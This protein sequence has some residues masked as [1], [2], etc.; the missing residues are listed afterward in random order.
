MTWTFQPASRS[1][2]QE[3]SAWDS[4]NASR[5]NHILLDSGFVSPLLRHFANGNVSLGINSDPAG[6]G[7]V[8][9][10]SCGLARWQSFQPSQ[11]PIGMFLLAQPDTS[12]EKLRGMMKRLPGFAVH[13]SV[14]QQ[15]PD[16]A[17]LSLSENRPDLERVDYIETARITIAGTFEDYWKQRGSN[18]RHNLARRRRR[19]TEKGFAAELVVRRS[20]AEVKDAIR[21]YGRLESMGWKAKDGTAVSADNAQGRFYADVFE[22]FCERG[23]AAIYQFVLNGNVV[24]SDLCLMRGGMMIVL[25]TAYDEALNEYSP[26]LLMRED[27]MKSVFAEGNIKLIEFYG[28]VMDWHRRWTDE[29]R[30]L[31]HVN[32]YRYEWLATLKKLVRRTG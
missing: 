23:E 7:M 14:L 4:I 13:M 17:S 28:R 8:L 6:A 29:V 15:D 5:G 22:H 32:C 18:L 3:R 2:Q 27:I 26:A 20:P 19:M 24:A 21:E 10:T 16:Y 30:V 9:L 12:G 25:K 31:Y 1:F 11:A